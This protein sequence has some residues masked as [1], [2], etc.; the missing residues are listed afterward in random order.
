MSPFSYSRLWRTWIQEEF[1]WMHI[2]KTSHDA[3]WPKSVVILR[4]CKFQILRSLLDFALIA[5]VAKFWR[6]CLFSIS[7]SLLCWQQLERHRKKIRVLFK[8]GLTIRWFFS[9]LKN[10]LDLFLISP[11]WLFY[12]HKKRIRINVSLAISPYCYFL[13]FF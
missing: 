10:E 8:Y 9:D 1:N 3:S 7:H 5:A 13:L 2:V 11:P 4:T 12:K 6:D